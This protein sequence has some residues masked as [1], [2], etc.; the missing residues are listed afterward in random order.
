MKLNSIE[1]FLIQE[2]KDLHSAETQLL[3]ALPKMAKAASSEELKEAFETHAQETATQVKRLEQA[4]E[5]FGG[6]P[7]GKTCE[8]MK[9]LI[10][11]AEEI[12]KAEGDESVKDAALIIAAQKVEHYEIAGYGSARALAEAL[13]YDEMAAIFSETLDEESA[14]DEKLSALAETLNAE[15][16]SVGE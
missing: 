6:S 5:E 9:G 4:M 15:A 16:V 13:G 8:A 1:D 12:M 14:T 11:E 2:V 7:R 10:A 3:K